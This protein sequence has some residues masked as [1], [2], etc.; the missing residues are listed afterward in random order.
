MIRPQV[1][2]K[3]AVRAVIGAGLGIA[4]LAGCMVGTA[5]ADD[6]E[7]L[8][9]KIFRGLME[10]LGLRR[11]DSGI[12]YRE[13][14]PLVVPPNRNLPQP[15]SKSTAER[16]PT[17]PN[18]PDVKRRTEAKAKR[19]DA[20]ANINWDEEKR[21]LRPD[22]LRGSGP[23]TAGNSR[24]TPDNR[25]VEGSPVMK[26]SEL[27]YKGGL[28]SSLFGGG[29]DEESTTFTGEAPR[30]SLIEPPTGYRTPSPNQPYGVGKEKYTPPKIEDRAV[31]A[32]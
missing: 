14:S 30:T 17:W 5:R 4:L 31:P 11:T 6:D 32:R 9:T 12:E 15:S 24:S 23:V 29:K 25:S 13:R 21:P 1:S 27:G 18:D 7:S 20:R 2:R 19:N 26:P 8:D 22:E 28:F 3:R 10:S 16:T